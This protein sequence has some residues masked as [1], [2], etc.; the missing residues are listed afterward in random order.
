VKADGFFADAAVPLDVSSRLLLP[1]LPVILEL[2]LNA[3]TEA[4]APGGGALLASRPIW[5]NQ[6]LPFDAKFL[7][8]QGAP[9]GIFARNAS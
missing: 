6:I 5:V 1:I 2:E 3:L 8:I 4:E 9:S 7:Q